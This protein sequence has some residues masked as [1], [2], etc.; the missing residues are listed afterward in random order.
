MANNRMYLVCGVCGD[1]LMIAR[2]LPPSWRFKCVGHEGRSVLLDGGEEL[3]ASGEAFDEWLV[4]HTHTV[5]QAGPTSFTVG[6]EA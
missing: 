5:S 3:V 2:Y 4:E 1:E 6:F